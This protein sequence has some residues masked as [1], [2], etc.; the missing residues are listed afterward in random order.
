VHGTRIVW[1]HITEKVDSCGGV[2]FIIVLT[3][4]Q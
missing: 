1:D 3:I 2:G 4:G